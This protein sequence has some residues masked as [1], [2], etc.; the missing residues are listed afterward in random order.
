MTN[1]SNAVWRRASACD[2]SGGSCVEVTNLGD[3][4]ITRDSK[5]PQG[6]VQAYTRSEWGA[7][8]DGVKK[9]EFDI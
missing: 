3:T 6:T 5:D 9:G 2:N 8:I 7:F 1:L 4:I